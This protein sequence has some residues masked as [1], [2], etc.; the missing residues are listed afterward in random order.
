MS[1]SGTKKRYKGHTTNYV[2][3]T[4]IVAASGGALFG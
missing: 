3:M 4:C 2:V 1:S